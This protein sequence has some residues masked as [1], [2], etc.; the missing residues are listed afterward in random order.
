LGGASNAVAKVK[1]YVEQVEAK[2][3]ELR[4]CPQTLVKKNQDAIEKIFGNAIINCEHRT[5]S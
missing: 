3:D 4:N 2:L 5:F 1:A